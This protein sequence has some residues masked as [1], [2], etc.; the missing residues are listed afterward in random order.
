VFGYDEISTKVLKACP[1]T[2]SAPL[3]YICNQYLASEIFPSRVKFSIVKPIFKDRS[4]N[5]M[6]NCR[7]ILCLPS[8]SEIFEKVIYLRL[9]QHCIENI[10]S[11]H[12]YGFR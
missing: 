4:K 10:L 3:A 1:K 8:F 2:I 7:P 6:S 12:Q 5:F 11:N 9:Y